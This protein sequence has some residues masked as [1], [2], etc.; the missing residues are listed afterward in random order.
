MRVSTPLPEL[1]EASFRD[2]AALEGIPIRK[3]QFDQAE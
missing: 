1:E 2:H 3:A